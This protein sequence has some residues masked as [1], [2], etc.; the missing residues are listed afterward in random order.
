MTLVADKCPV[1]NHKYICQLSTTCSQWKKQHFHQILLMNIIDS[2]NWTIFFIWVSKFLNTIEN[3]ACICHYF[4]QTP[5]HVIPCIPL[6]ILVISQWLPLASPA[7]DGIHNI[8]T[9]TPGKQ[10]ISQTAVWLKLPTT[11]VKPMINGPGVILLTLLYDTN[12]ADWPKFH[13]VSTASSIA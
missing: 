5:A 10:M 7:S 8:R 11:V 13:V 4:F 3:E 1:S 2:V 6:V 9:F 12:S